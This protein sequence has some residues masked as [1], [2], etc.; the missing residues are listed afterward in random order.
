MRFTRRA[1]YFA[2]YVYLLL[3]FAMLGLFVYALAVGS[4]AATIAGAGLAVFFASAVMGFRAAA[5]Q[6]AE[7]NESGIHVDGVNV[8][9]KNLRREQ[10]ARYLHAYRA[11]QSDIEPGSRAGSATADGYQRA[12]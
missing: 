2:A 7:S 1:S 8:W 4:P 9:A 3:S 5:R 6:R 10:I 12:A 11:A